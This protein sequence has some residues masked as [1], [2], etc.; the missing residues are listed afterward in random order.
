MIRS[1]EEIKVNYDDKWNIKTKD[2]LQVWT[3]IECLCVCVNGFSAYG[4]REVDN[5]I[6]CM[7][8]IKW[9]VE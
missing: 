2:Q 1:E 6:P 5:R 8:D 9:F 4:F 7:V 3:W